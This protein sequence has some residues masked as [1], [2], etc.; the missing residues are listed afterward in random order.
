MLLETKTCT[1][2]YA[3]QARLDETM[4]DGFSNPK[5]CPTVIV[6]TVATCLIYDDQNPLPPPMNCSLSSLA[7]DIIDDLSLVPYENEPLL[8]NPAKTFVLDLEFFIQDGQ[9]R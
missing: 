6:P 4:F 5:T 2:N 9:N 1:N 8:K 7:V 3:V